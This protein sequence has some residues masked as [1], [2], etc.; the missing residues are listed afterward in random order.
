MFVMRKYVYLVHPLLF[1]T[2]AISKP[3]AM[4]F[5]KKKAKETK[6]LLEEK[7]NILYI[8]E[9]LCRCDVLN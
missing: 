5:S 4:A 3:E 9:R 8:V 7:F 1:D 6:D 2:D